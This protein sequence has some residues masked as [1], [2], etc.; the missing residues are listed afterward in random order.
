MNY[1]L[2]NKAI[3][4]T[5][6]VYIDRM[7]A[8][9]V[10]IPHILNRLKLGLITYRKHNMFNKEEAEFVMKV[11]QD[12]KLKEIVHVEVSHLLFILTV[13]KLWIEIV[14]KKQRPILGVSDN[15]L[16]KGRAVYAVQML[17]LKQTDK[18]SYEEKK[19]IIDTSVETAKRFMDY[20]LE[21][22][23]K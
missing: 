19:Q 9:K 21:K 12:P 10:E 6:D 17:K 7:K 1:N 15:K 20:H 8:D 23:I 13:I 11:G 16:S 2:L 22:L 4:F 3:L 18:E 14:P 5:I